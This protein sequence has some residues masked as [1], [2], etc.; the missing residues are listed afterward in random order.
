[1]I[2]L[3][4]N[5]QLNGELTPD[6]SIKW[7]MDVFNN[8]SRWSLFSIYNTVYCDR[9]CGMYENGSPVA[10][11]SEWYKDTIIETVSL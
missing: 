8:T 3:V 4:W 2:R 10:I 6:I 7:S 9:I 11:D 5:T 1:M